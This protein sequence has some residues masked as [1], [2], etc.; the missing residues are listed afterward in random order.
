M[1]RKSLENAA[2]DY[3]NLRGLLA[4]PLGGLIVVAALSNWEWGPFGS[5]WVF[6]AFGALTFAGVVLITRMYNERY[7]R[8]TASTE[9]QVRAGVATIGVVAVTLAGSSVLRSELSWSLDLPVNGLA[10]SL[11]A[12][13]LA[14]Y[15]ATI[16]I[17][18]HHAAIWGALLVA[19]LL[20]VWG[21][22]SV[23]DTSNAGLVLVG[24]ASMISGV[25]DH[26]LL[27][28]SFGGA[29]GFDLRA[30]DVGV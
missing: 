27:A 6:L 5:S 15:A 30:G 4:L 23:E 1:D 10:A 29:H 18:A 3:V 12:G 8:V 28:R 7:G 2:Q 26:R 25:L 16:G 20:P 13:F 24:V 11:A 9:Q 17:R 21:G 19:A 22:L 14:Y